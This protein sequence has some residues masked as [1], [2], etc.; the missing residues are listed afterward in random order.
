MPYCPRCKYEYNPGVSKCPD[1]DEYLV[2]H[3]SLDPDEVRVDPNDDH[4]DWI[5][6]A[7]FSS[8]QY[9]TML[10][11]GLRAKDIPVV[12]HSSTGLFAQFGGEM[13]KPGK[14]TYAIM[15]L[16]EYI[17]D[18][19]REANLMLGEIWEKAKLIDIV[20]E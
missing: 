13:F 15:I 14:D 19:D 1:C 5:L 20:E 18:A 6:I 8:Y 11:E 9:A 4:Q 7:R 3:L 17:E 12:I 2:E 10:V 16:K